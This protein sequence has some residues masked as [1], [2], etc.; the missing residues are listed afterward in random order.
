MRETISLTIGREGLPPD[1]EF[2]WSVWYFFKTLVAQKP[3]SDEN[4]YKYEITKPGFYRIRATI[5]SA[6]SFDIAFSPYKYVPPDFVYDLDRKQAR[7]DFERN[8]F[9]SRRR[10]QISPY[11]VSVNDQKFEFIYFP[12]T[13]TTLFVLCP[14]AIIRGQFPVPYFYRWEWAADGKFP[15]NVIVVSDPTFHLDSGLGAG[16][17]VGTKE[18]D[19]TKNFSAI[20]RLITSTL[21]IANKD[22]VF[23]GSSA[24]GFIA[25][26]FARHFPGSAAVAVNCQT[27]I[28]RYDAWQPLYKYGF[29]G[30][31]SEEINANY[32][33]RLSTIVNIPNFDKNRIFMVQ[34]TEDTHHYRDHF[35]PFV[36]KVMPAQEATLPEGITRIEGSPFTF[37][38]YSHPDGHMAETPEMAEAL[39]QMALRNRR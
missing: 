11:E 35:M 30:L 36:K 33:D 8:I 17:F 28:W 29:P 4:S 24:G 34:N 10:M 27:E 37:W 16:W 2:A 31:D 15:G 22:L 9:S 14:S 26:Q 3:F 13:L 7:A 38:I 5:K 18:K 19:A 20:L 25:M 39:I 21:D 12:S 6:E 23:W 1:T 32:K